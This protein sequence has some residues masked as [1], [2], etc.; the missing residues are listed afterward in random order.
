VVKPFP[1]ITDISGAL[2]GTHYTARVNAYYV[3]RID[4]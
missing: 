2:H 3:I 1:I 4:K